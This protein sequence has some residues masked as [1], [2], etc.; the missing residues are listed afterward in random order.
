M[1]IA[2]GFAVDAWM[3]NIPSHV[4]AA[5]TDSTADTTYIT[6]NGTYCEGPNPMIQPWF[7]VVI[8]AL[9]VGVLV[10]AWR[11][12]RRPFE[13]PRQGF[14][15]L[16]AWGAP[17]LWLALVP[18]IAV[19]LAS[20][21]FDSEVREPTCQITPEFIFGYTAKCP[22]SALVPSVLIPGLLNLVT[23]RWLWTANPRTR[24]AAVVA[25]ALG[26]AELGGGLWGL[27]AQGPM[28]EANSNFFGPDLPP[29]GPYGFTLGTV[30]WLLTLLSLLVIAKL[31]LGMADFKL[32]TRTPAG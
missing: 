15:A 28:V 7:G 8:T 13:R 19:P 25:S 32:A 29:L 9:G 18:I 1:L 11:V 12:D 21:L 22:V 31:P 16:R 4:R 5:C 3:L 23:L 26:A 24:I 2:A 27:F 17:L 30:I 6:A 14:R 10:M 20:F